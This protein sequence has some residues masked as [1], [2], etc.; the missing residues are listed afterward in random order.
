MTYATIGSR[1]GNPKV[2]LEPLFGRQHGLATRQQLLACGID[3]EAIRLELRNRRWQR[4]LPGLYSNTTGTISVEQRRVAATL[5]TSPRA[6]LTG[7]AALVW[8][9][10]RH[11][12]ADPFM[13]IL[14]PHQL[15]RSSRGFVR[16]HRTERLDRRATSANGYTV[17]SVPRSA[18]DACRGLSSIRDVRAIVA[19]AVQ[20]SLTTVPA[21]EHE[22]AMAG[23]SHTALLRRA[24]REIASG[25]RS[26]PEAEF[27]ELFPT[28][29]SLPSIIWNPTLRVDDGTTLPSPDGWIP[30]VGIALEVDSREYHLGPEGW[31]RTMR[32][33]NLLSSYGAMVLHFTPSE[34]RQ[35]KRSVRGVVERAY[36][37]RLASGVT[38]NIRVM[39]AP[40]TQEGSPDQ[41]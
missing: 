35:R 41:A 6:Q 12:P 1:A 18:A 36:A 8:H 3:D 27:H 7:I 9:G 4:I 30:E 25:A 34:I 32:R 16:V 14:V 5:F 28:G 21:L 39:S 38:V 33:H 22:L 15:R 37:E 11:C 19:E 31:Q 23:T 40:G 20:R 24:I 13:H 29:G 17:C 10:F 2:D 26:A